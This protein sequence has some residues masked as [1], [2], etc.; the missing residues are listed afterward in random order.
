M[1]TEQERS[2]WAAGSALELVSTAFLAESPDLSGDVAEYD[3]DFALEVLGFIQAVKR[4]AKTAEDAV[5]AL[6]ADHLGASKGIMF[7]GVWYFV[8]PDRKPQVHDPSALIHYL[9]DDW[10]SVVP[11]TK[12]NI[13][14]LKK[15]V[16]ARGDSPN[17]WQS[18]MEYV[19]GETPKL[20]QT[21]AE[22]APLYAQRAK[23]GE[24]V[25]RPTRKPKGIA[26]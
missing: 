12:A 26:S 20:Q 4:A 13:G 5:S 15:L 11:P 6:V 19:E 16:V 3:R 23:E 25:H 14:A 17:A 21:S 9:R 10:P 8:G 24:L 18:F 22:Y 7:Q 1:T 2:G